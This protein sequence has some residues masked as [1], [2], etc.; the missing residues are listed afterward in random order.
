MAQYHEIFDLQGGEY[1]CAQC[2]VPL[3]NGPMTLHYMGHD[4]P[5]LMPKCPVCGQGLIPESL[6]LG[7]ILEVERGLED[8]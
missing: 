1:L 8:K 3:E 2:G 4:F 5:I 7:K 6:A